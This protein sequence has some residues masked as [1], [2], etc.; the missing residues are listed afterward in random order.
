MSGRY[1]PGRKKFRAY[2][3]ELH[4]ALRAA[5][6]YVPSW[7]PAEEDP[8]EEWLDLYCSGCFRPNDPITTEQVLSV[9]VQILDD[10][11]PVNLS[12]AGSNAAADARQPAGKAA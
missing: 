1:T 2:R 12:A 10:P 3:R 9:L 7:R 4:R 11:A 8:R 5:E 6:E